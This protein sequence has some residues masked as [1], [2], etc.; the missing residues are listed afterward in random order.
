MISTGFGNWCSLINVLGHV[1]VTPPRKWTRVIATS[2]SRVVFSFFF[3]RDSPVV[4]IKIQTNSQ[5]M[6]TFVPYISHPPPP[7]LQASS[8]LISFP[9]LGCILMAWTRWTSPGG[10][11]E[12]PFSPEYPKPLCLQAPICS[13]WNRLS[14]IGLGRMQNFHCKW[15]ISAPF[16]LTLSSQFHRWWDCW[17]DRL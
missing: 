15:N 5:P 17:K 3:L 10:L 14:P 2:L 11:A 7:K 16:P 9:P 1:P 12:T 6:R 4:I 8:G 13:S